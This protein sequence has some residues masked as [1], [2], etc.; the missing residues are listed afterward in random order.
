MLESVLALEWICREDGF[1]GGWRRRTWGEGCAGIYTKNRVGHWRCVGD[2]RRLLN[3]HERLASRGQ[4]E[5]EKG[6]AARGILEWWIQA[7]RKLQA[8]EAI[9]ARPDSF[10]AG[11]VISTGCRNC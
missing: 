6:E 3:R 7:M 2:D 4:N 5:N 8:L 11:K 9:F 1:R 10:H